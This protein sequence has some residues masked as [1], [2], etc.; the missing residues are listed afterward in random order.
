MGIVRSPEGAISAFDNVL[1]NIG[2]INVRGLDLT[3]AYRMPRQSFGRLRANWQSSYLLA[4]ETKTP[5][6]TGVKVTDLVGTIS[7]TPTHAFPRFKSNLTLSW[8][9]Q[10]FDVT[11]VTRYIHS[12]TEQCPGLAAFPGTC[13][14]PNKDDTKSTNKLG[15]TVYNDVQVVWS[16]DFDH[17]LTVTAGVNNLLNRD[18]PS[19]Y[20]C[21]LNGFEGA[22]Y[23]VPG[24]FGYLSATY[25]MQ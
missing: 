3:L 17:R 16:P 15:I 22:T 24:V 5:S 7:G 8:L 20:S 12:V 13:S 2:G 25:H 18:P 19:C 14:D 1:Q 21:S 4:Y 11:L 9:Y 6:A 23:D 10:A